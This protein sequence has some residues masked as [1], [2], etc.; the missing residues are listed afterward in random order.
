MPRSLN[1]LTSL[2]LLLLPLAGNAEQPER[3]DTLFVQTSVYTVH[4][5]PDP[6]HVNR[7]NL[8][9]IEYD[10]AGGWLLGGEPAR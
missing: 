1:G 2:C 4:F 9:G 8:L 3:H 6:D 7:Q 10:N 5:D